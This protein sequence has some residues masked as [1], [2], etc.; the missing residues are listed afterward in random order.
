ME[1][2]TSQIVNLVGKV[3][4]LGDKCIGF[5]FSSSILAIR[6]F[7]YAACIDIK[8]HNRHPSPGKCRG[9]RYADIS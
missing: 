9:H 3:Q 1:V 5:D 4:A 7:S 2:G 6:E 8:T